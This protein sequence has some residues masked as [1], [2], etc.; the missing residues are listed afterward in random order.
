MKIAKQQLLKLIK[1]ELDAVMKEAE[2]D[3]EE[4]LDDRRAKSKPAPFKKG[5]VG[6]PACYAA[7][8]GS[9]SR[10]GQRGHW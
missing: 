4:M 6:A 5:P 8:A 10:P 9:G 3:L 1:E 2:S 7:G